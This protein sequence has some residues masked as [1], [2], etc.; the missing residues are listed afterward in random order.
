MV[1]ESCGERERQR[2]ESDIQADMC[3]IYICIY[4][5]I[6]TY[7]NNAVCMS[8]HI[9]LAKAS[10]I[11][12]RVGASSRHEWT[13]AAVPLDKMLHNHELSVLTKRAVNEG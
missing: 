12:A 4:I 10:L 13:R 2:I 3:N 7:N 5:Y 6:Y 11:G 9:P 8:I 1:A